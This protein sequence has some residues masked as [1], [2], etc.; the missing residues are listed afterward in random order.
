MLRDILLAREACCGLGPA[1]IS[2][3]GVRR[4]A[5]ELTYTRQREEETTTERERTSG[6]VNA[7]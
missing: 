5:S 2:K 4:P 7:C 1:D 6:G 3:A